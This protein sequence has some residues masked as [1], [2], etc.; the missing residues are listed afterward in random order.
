MSKDTKIAWCKPTLIEEL[1]KGG[2]R[3]LTKSNFCNFGLTCRQG[4]SGKEIK[5][6][7]AINAWLHRK[8]YNINLLKYHRNIIEVYMKEREMI[9]AHEFIKTKD[10][11]NSMT[12]HQLATFWRELTCYHRG[13]AKD[14]P[15]SKAFTSAPEIVKGFMFKDHVPNFFLEDEE[16][17]WTLERTLQMCPTFI[18]MQTKYELFPSEICCGDKNCREGEHN[19]KDVACEADYMTGKCKC[20]SEEEIEKKKKSNDEESSSIKKELS[21]S[22]DSD[23]FKITLT[24]K[25]QKEKEAR[26]DVLNKENNALYRMVHYTERG[27]IPYNVQLKNE[28]D[29]KKQ[30]ELAKVAV[31]EKK[32]VIVKKKNY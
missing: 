4:H 11:I 24:K 6:K 22:I 21:G 1:R 5:Y 7:P 15:H 12:F 19:P 32:V 26:I 20:L 13:L 16:D 10:E 14:L 29:L 30:E 31:V 9:K 23:G 8:N 27:L 3:V 25:I 28:E 17:M 18:K 2:V